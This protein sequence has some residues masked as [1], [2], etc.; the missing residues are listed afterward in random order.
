MPVQFS[1]AFAC[2]PRAIGTVDL[3]IKNI[4]PVVTADRHC[5]VVHA[6]IA[7][8]LAKMARDAANRSGRQILV[9]P[10]VTK[11]VPVGDILIRTARQARQKTKW[12]GVAEV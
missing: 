7:K 10:Y 6:A 4:S 5:Q 2:N 1:G 9:V 8:S 3:Q 12:K 11:Q